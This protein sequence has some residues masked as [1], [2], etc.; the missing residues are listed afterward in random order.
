[1]PDYGLPPLNGAPAPV[2]RHRISTASPTTGRCRTSPVASALVEHRIS[3][4]QTLRNQT[5]YSHYTT[6]AV[7]TGA[8]RVGTYRERR[9]HGIADD[10]DG[11]SR[12]I[13]RRARSTSFS[14]ATIAGSTMTRST[15]R[16]TSSTDFSTGSVAHTL[17]AG[18]GDRARHVRQP[19]LPSRT[20]RASAATR[21]WQSSRSISRPTRAAP[22]NAVRTAGNLVNSTADTLAAYFNDTAA[23]NE[24]WQLVWGL[25]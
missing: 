5:Q 18:A 3:N 14:A 10:H 13:C 22:A 9:V 21:V 15:T 23:L 11:Q 12:P 25:R 24:Q 16:P 1:M 6:D 4:T 7:E 17:L 20:I 19:G 2:D 8:S